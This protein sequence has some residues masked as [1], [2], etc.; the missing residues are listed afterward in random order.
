M[1]DLGSPDHSQSSFIP[2]PNR[3][4]GSCEGDQRLL[5]AGCQLGPWDDGA[6]IDFQLS[7][8]T[9]AGIGSRPEIDGLP[10]EQE[11]RFAADEVGLEEFPIAFNAGCSV[12]HFPT[13]EERFEKRPCSK[14]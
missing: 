6:G 9:P 13:T 1:N 10:A 2:I 8:R 5:P 4:L 3:S 14:K 12:A 11:L 7:E